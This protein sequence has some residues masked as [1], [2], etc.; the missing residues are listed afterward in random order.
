MKRYLNQ[1]MV[2]AL[3]AG[4]LS[5]SGFLVSA[6][7]VFAKADGMLEN[8][9]VATS[10]MGVSINKA[11]H[12][13]LVG[14]LASVSGSMLTINS[15]GGAWTINTANAKL[16]RR[17]GAASSVAEFQV[18]DLI[19]VNGEISTGAWTISAKEVR[20]ESIQAKNANPTGLISNLNT[21]GGTFTLT[22]KAGK[23][24]AI[25]TSSTTSIRLNSKSGAATLT[26]LSNGL[27]AQVWGVMDTNQTSIAATRIVASLKRFNL[28]GTISAPANNS[29]VLVGTNQASTTVT[30]ADN[31][32]ITINGKGATFANLT[33]GM[34]V[35]VRGF[36]ADSSS[37]V[38][39]N[40]VMARTKK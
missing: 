2:L 25:T 18:G 37:P 36:A 1:K 38:T 27:T 12:A 6:P 34:I 13:T 22:T 11:G 8:A 39:A 28:A 10:T 33:D 32:K 19:T 29:F 20:D 31:A 5:L 15:W 30:L 21:A 26:D 35:K 9:S 23:A 7:A 14:T 4:S 40:V 3:A 24:Y 16:I 17:F